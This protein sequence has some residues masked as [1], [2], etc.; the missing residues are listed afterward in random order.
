MKSAVKAITISAT[1]FALVMIALSHSTF[2]QQ[3]KFIHFPINVFDHPGIRGQRLTGEGENEGTG[4][5]KSLRDRSSRYSL[6]IPSLD[7]RPGFDENEISG[8]IPYKTVEIGIES[9]NHGGRR[10]DHPR[11]VLS[12]DTGDGKSY[13]I[14]ALEIPG[15]VLALNAFDRIV[16]SDEVEDG[17]KVFDT[18][19]DTFW[20]HLIH[21]P[22][23]Y[24]KDAFHV[25]QF[26]HPY[27]GSLYHGFARSAG[28]NFWE[29]LGYTFMGSFLWET[30][31]ETTNPSI[32]DQIA[33][34]IAGSF[35]GEVLFRS[36]GLLLESGGGKPGF[37][38]ELGAAVLSP[39][40]GFNRLIFGDRFKPVFPSRNP[41]I[42][43]WVRV[44]AGRVVSNQT[45]SS[46]D[47]RNQ[48][49]LNYSLS[50]GLPGKPGYNYTRPFDYFR[51]EVG[52]A[53]RANETFENITTRGLLLGKKYEAGEAYRGI[54]GLYGGFDYISVPFFRVSSTTASLGTTAQWWLGRD[55][56]LQGTVLGG[57]GFGAGGEA[58][59]EGN[60][61][62]HFGGIGRGV[63]AL[64][65]I[66]GD[67]VMFNMTGR[68]YS[69]SN[70]GSGSPGTEFIG[71]LETGITAR[72]YGRHG[73]GI[74]YIAFGRDGHGA[75]HSTGTQTLGTLSLVYTLLGDIRFGA[76]EW[77]K[78]NSP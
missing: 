70:I 7:G 5:W 41:A 28:L 13:L 45:G 49:S 9:E 43:H 11:P 8:V 64:R 25:N 76:V 22:W 75:G 40:T 61:D 29:S 37:W 47:H 71:H 30:A 72:V 3:A 50:Y 67:A 31:G 2:A 16:F 57:V 74:Q 33:S 51:L 63:L 68:V 24:D 1:S 23:R 59:R 26:L 58:P 46:I 53:S 65:L 18:D 35:F 78:E 56:A 73:L 52:G 55:I 27:Q 14:P 20:D 15:F 12:W 42:F 34:G 77:R 62:Y 21:G 19:L 4:A 36:A 10:L 54:W 60:R 66:F 48:V 32:N 44:G 69:I 17:K 6:I 39:P 38:R